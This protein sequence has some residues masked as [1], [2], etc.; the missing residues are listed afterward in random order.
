MRHFQLAFSGPWLLA[1]VIDTRTPIQKREQWADNCFEQVDEK[2]DAW[3]A[4]RFV[5]LFRDDRR[6]LF[7]QT[8]QKALWCWA[9]SILLS[10][11][12][13]EFIHWRNRSRSH[14]HDLWSNFVAKSVNAGEPSARPEA[15]EGIEVVRACAS[16]QDGKAAESH[17]LETSC[18]PR[19][20]LPENVGL[21]DL[22]DI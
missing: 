15:G 22:R 5:R 7:Q 8:V 1:T 18:D 19:R 16:D 12:S 13:V 6:A 9:W 10:V 4:I 2:R 20:W 21:D 14:K 17:Q 11:V 3:L